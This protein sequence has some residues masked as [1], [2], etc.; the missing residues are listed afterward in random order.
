MYFSE[1]VHTVHVNYSQQ[2]R[3]ITFRAY[4][5]TRIQKQQCL[6]LHALHLLHFIDQ[7]TIKKQN[8]FKTTALEDE[9]KEIMKRRLLIANPE[10]AGAQK[11]YTK[12]LFG[13]HCTFSITW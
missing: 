7:C 6:S 9:K 2:V 11:A 12:H 8:D 13:V 4:E 1:C 10:S 5:S 3:L